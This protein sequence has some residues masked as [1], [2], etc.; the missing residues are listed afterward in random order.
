[1]ANKR[2]DAVRA[3]KRVKKSEFTCLGSLFL[4][5]KELPKIPEKENQASLHTERMCKLAS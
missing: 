5:E 4:Y 1:M 2:P 3:S